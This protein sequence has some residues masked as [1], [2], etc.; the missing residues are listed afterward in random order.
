MRKRLAA[1]LIAATA[2]IGTGGIAMATAA[3][4]A[5]VAASNASPGVVVWWAQ[6]A[7]CPNVVVWWGCPN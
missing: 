5:P 3:S 6:P 4:A 2:I 1:A 7:G